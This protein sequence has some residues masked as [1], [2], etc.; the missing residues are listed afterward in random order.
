MTFDG[1]F[2]SVRDSMSSSVSDFDWKNNNINV[3]VLMG[4]PYWGTAKGL[5]P[6]KGFLADGDQPF[7]NVLGMEEHSLGDERDTFE[8]T[9]DGHVQIAGHEVKDLNDEYGGRTLT[10]FPTNSAVENLG[11]KGTA[12]IAASD[13]INTI[14]P[15][16]LY[17]IANSKVDQHWLFDQSDVPI[18]FFTEVRPTGDQ[19]CQISMKR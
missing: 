6:R 13:Q 17:S 7:L 11:A 8:V 15:R 12:A 18:P 10:V 14:N 19:E 1:E 5:D 16:P 4:D 9:E 3:A 2:T